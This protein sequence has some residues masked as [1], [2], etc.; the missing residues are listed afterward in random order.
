[1]LRLQ[2]KIRSTNATVDG[3]EGLMERV[4]GKDRRQGK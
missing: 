1:M 2:G 3:L 4:I